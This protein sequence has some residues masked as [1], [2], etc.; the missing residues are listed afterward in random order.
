MHLK[1][2]YFSYVNP[3]LILVSTVTGGV[4]ISAFT[5]LVWVPLGITSSA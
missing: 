1:E 5:S 4:S 3:L 2:K